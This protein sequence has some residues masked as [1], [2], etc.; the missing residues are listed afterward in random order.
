[1]CGIVVTMS[2]RFPS[3]FLFGV[4]TS[5]YQIE[6]AEFDNGASASIWS[7]FSRRKGAIQDGSTG[8]IA[9]DHYHRYDDDV[10]LMAEMGMKAY[11]F[12]LSWA[13][14]WP[15]DSGIPN[16]DG[17]AFYRDLLKTLHQ[18]DIQ[19][20]ITL[21]HWDLP[22]YLHAK[23]GWISPDS[24][25]W[26]ANYALKTVALFNDLCDDFI[27]LNEP[28][29]F[30]HKG[31]L[32]GEHAPGLAD[33][34]SAGSAYVNIL[35]AHR[36]SMEKL[37]EAFPSL[38]FSIACNLAQIDAASE[39]PDDIAAA[40]R[41]H[42]Y[43][44][45]LFMLPWFKGRIPQIAYD[46]FPEETSTLKSLDGTDP[47]RHDMV[48][49]N[50][51]SRS[52]VRHSEG[53]FL[54]AE[55]VTPRGEVT[56]MNWE[57]SPAGFT[58]VLLWTHDL[59]QTPIWVTENGSAW[60]D[61]VENGEILDQRRCDYLCSHLEAMNAAIKAG[62]DVRAYFAWSLMDNFEWECGYEQRFGLV[63]VDFNTQKRTLKQSGRL[64]SEIVR[65]HEPLLEPN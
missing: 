33:R 59:T 20:V 54:D 18:A 42:S 17:V 57:I 7:E 39:S 45:E 64:Y 22:M 9:C 13:R 62:A 26:F 21:Y 61:V 53:S 14:I 38:H 56:S 58:E 28:W 24:P 31:Y 50:Y 44:N 46:L 4:A 41:H 25:A 15:D 63:H 30:M 47:I 34:K 3:T 65:S 52:I 19:P 12:S 40:E 55:F 35:R 2:P 36:L 6:G 1:M 23:G 27:T 5:S 37:R 49:I 60:H 11:R 32:T 51:Y 10:A 48:C 8:L 29:V 16:P 43:M